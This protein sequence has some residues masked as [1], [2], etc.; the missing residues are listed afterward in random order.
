MKQQATFPFFRSVSA[1]M[2]ERYIFNFR[3]RPEE[4]AKKIQIPWLE[5]QVVNGWSAVSFCI[6]WLKKLAVVPFPPLFNFETISC[7]YRVGV[8]DK[9]VNPPEPSVYVTDRWADLSLIAR[10]APWILFDTI[11]MTKSAIGHAGDTTHLQ[12]SYLDG[13]HLFS[14]EVAPTT[15]FQSEVFASVDDFATFI[16]GGVSSWA[17]SIYDGGVTKVDLYKEDVGYTPLQA[18]VEYSELNQY[19]R[20]SGLVLDSAVRARGAEYKWTFRGLYFK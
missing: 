13:T 20:E 15:T 10:L 12:M 6:L 11:P 17:A 16:K 7:A 5:P 18:T 14:A 9:S 2:E 4:L 19:W 1:R 8:I 3:L